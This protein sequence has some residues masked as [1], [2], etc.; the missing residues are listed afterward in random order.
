VRGGA[1][2]EGKRRW[3][4]TRRKEQKSRSAK[5]AKSSKSIVVVGML[6]AAV[7]VLF[8]NPVTKK[9]CC[10]WK[11]SRIFIINNYYER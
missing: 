1:K 4:K 7:V 8:V 11:R 5:N 2:E 6:G 9:V 3:D 10:R